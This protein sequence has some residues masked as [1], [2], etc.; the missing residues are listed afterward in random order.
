MRSDELIGRT[1]TAIPQEIHQ[2]ARIPYT[3]VR[4]L[5]DGN[6]SAVPTPTTLSGSPDRVYSY[7]KCI[8]W[9]NQLGQWF[10]V[11]RQSSRTTNRHIS[12]VVAELEWSNMNPITVDYHTGEPA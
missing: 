7:A 4:A 10:V 8:A 9:R 12:A 5:L 11:D 3:R 2:M 1:G 6:P